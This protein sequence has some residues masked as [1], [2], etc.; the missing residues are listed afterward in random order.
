MVALQLRHDD[1]RLAGCGDDC[2]SIRVIQPGQLGRVEVIQ[3]DPEAHETWGRLNASP[4]GGAVV[5]SGPLVVDRVR[6]TVHVGQR[7]VDVTPRE[8]AILDYLA[9]HVGRI[10]TSDE[11]LTA[12]WGSGWGYAVG[13]LRTNMTRLRQKLGPC[14]A[15]LQNAPGRGY[16]LV[17][18]NPAENA[19]IPALPRLWAKAW[20]RCRVC[21]R[22]DRPH[23]G[24]GRCDPCGKRAR[25]NGGG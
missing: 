17:A 16:R 5:A 25:R 3:H 2:R 4:L 15:L 22:D 13:M 7:E 20:D 14:G 19:P 10:C 23:G 6:R 9:E 18:A 8:W 21:G 11:I 12:G 1:W 24:R